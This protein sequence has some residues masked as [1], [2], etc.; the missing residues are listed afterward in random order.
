MKPTVYIKTYGCQMNVRDSE[1]ALALLE[2]HGYA[3]AATESEAGI[4]LLNTCSVRGK[5][6]AKAIGKLGLLVASKRT[7]P[8]RRIG[9]MGCMVQRL[10]EA[11][12]D[13]VPGLDFAVGTDA[14]P[15]LP[16]IL[17][18]VHSG[19]RTVLDVARY[20]HSPDDPEGHTTA[21]PSAFVNILYGCNRGCTYCVV[22]GVRGREWSRQAESV[23]A[24]VASRV[25]QGIREVTVLGQSVMSYGVANDVW[26]G[27]PARG[28]RYREAFPQLLATLSEIEGLSRL[29]F[30]SGHPSGC[31][32]EL[33]DA[34]ADLPPVCEHI[35]L[36]L[37]SGSD[38]ILRLMRRGYTVADYRAAVEALRAR[39]PQLAVTTDI[40]VGFPTESD[41]EFSKTRE[42]MD[43][44]AFDSA[45]IF[46]YSA[47]PG[48]VAADWEDTVSADEK[49]R[50]N[51]ALLD[52]QKR[53]ARAFNTAYVGRTVEVL[54]EG[55]SKRNTARW[56]GRTRT[57]KIVVFE[58]APGLAVGQLRQVRIEQSTPLSLRGRLADREET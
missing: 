12:F 50:R 15:R 40:I 10:Q 41:G 53:R 19:E 7:A 8:T 28:A 52:D 2:A 31:S 45:F 5:A 48:T 21:G 57:N 44:M 35:H 38:R 51:H 36:P 4:V 24:E 32:R 14:L 3:R 49:M 43:E 42:F 33:A 56:A 23:R 11:L 47:R 55:P 30:T 58:P 9:A 22:P 13:E 6:E 25:E 18:R 20:P 39:V 1:R 54:V 34:M 26:T 16:R 37:Q 29:R 46:K 27:G 17:E